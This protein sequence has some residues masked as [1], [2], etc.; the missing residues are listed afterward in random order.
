MAAVCG[1]DDIFPTAALAVAFST[2]EEIQRLGGL[3]KENAPRVTLTRFLRKKRNISMYVCV[4]GRSCPKIKTSVTTRA[5]RRCSLGP[6]SV[7]LALFSWSYCSSPATLTPMHQ[8]SPV[9]RKITKTAFSIRWTIR[10]VA[11]NNPVIKITD[12]KPAL[13]S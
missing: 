13:Q 9:H 6:P 2:V 3:Q 4:V 10:K 12:R 11:I 1:I 8:A 7:Y 5:L